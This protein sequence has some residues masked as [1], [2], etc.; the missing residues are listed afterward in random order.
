MS[1]GYGAPGGYGTGAGY[2]GGGPPPQPGYPGAPQSGYPGAPQAGYPG[3]P[4]AG[5][6]GA[7]PPAG[8]PGAP[9]Q[10]GYGY[11]YG[12]DPQVVAWFQ[13]VDAD[14]SGQI[15][16]MELRQ[17]LT[18]SNYSH[19]NEEACRLMIGMFDKD[20]NGTINLNEFQ[21]L[22][23][24]MNQWKG[25]FDRFDSNRS[26]SI[27]ANELCNAFNELGY[28]VSMQFSQL[29]C[30]KYDTQGRRALTLDSFIQACV[31]LKML[32]DSFRQRDTSMTGTVQM[33]YE[34][35]MCMAMWNKP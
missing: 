9:P 17:A 10:P 2:G 32:T 21:Q 31:L 14:R 5:Y 3:A 1:Y 27:E 35:F 23:T 24:Y 18:N 25:T 13:A 15:S 11:G 8:Y 30:T 16:A 20:M 7:P 22:W 12:V 26:G 28:R 29:V 4:Q 34:D 33:S 6:P 19:F